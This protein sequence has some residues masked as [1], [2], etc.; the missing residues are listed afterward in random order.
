MKQIKKLVLAA[1]C[2]A[3]AL[4]S[5]LLIVAACDSEK[6]FTVTVAQYNTEQGSVSVS[7]P[8]EGELY[9]EG[10][11]VTVTVTPKGNYTGRSLKVNGQDAEIQTGGGYIL[12]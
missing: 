12:L 7:K 6:G 10:E 11:T 4:T 9:D 2:V 8:A 1:L 5:T 3:L